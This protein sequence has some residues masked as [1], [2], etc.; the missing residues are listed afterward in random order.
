MNFFYPWLP[1]PVNRRRDK[2]QQKITVIY[3][4]IINAKRKIEG[5]Y[6]NHEDDM[7]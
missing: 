1:L 2:A 3:K 6:E 5:S 7:I 4:G